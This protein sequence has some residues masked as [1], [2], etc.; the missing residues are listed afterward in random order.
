M[1]DNPWF[2]AFVASIAIGGGFTILRETYFLSLRMNYKQILRV[3]KSA[4][5]QIGELKQLCLDIEQRRKLDA[6]QE[7]LNTGTKIYNQVNDGQA[8]ASQ[9]E[10][11][12]HER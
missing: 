8:Q 7:Q 11:N 6:I 10:H 4:T 12:K 3:V 1:K 9:G 5:R 2:W